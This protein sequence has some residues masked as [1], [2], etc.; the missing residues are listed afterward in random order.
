MAE[1]NRSTRP[2]RT[3]RAATGKHRATEKELLSFVPEKYRSLTWSLLLLLTLL[4]FFGGPIFGG[5]Y[6][7]ANDNISWESYRTYLNDMSDKGESPQWMPYVF[8]GMPGVAAYMVTGDRN[9]DLTMKGLQVAQ[10]VFS[11]LNQDIMRVL[12]Y[13]FLLGLG[14]F[15][16]LR[17]KGLSRPV[18]FFAAFAT[19]FSTWI[20]VWV[21]IGHN[22]KPMVLAFLPWIILFADRLIDRWSYLYAG[23]LILAIHYLVESAHPQTA[24]YGAFLI[25]IWLL[26]EFIASFVRKD[27][28]STGV[29]RAVLVG[30]AAALFAV[31]M[32]W[33]R[34]AVTLEY[35]EYSTRGA[36]PIM[37][38]TEQ[39]P[40]S[41]A[42]SWSQDVDETFTYIVPTYFGFGH[43]QLDVAGLPKEPIPTYW[44]NEKAPFTDA[45]HYM[46]ILVLLLSIYGFIRYRSNPFVLGIGIAGI[47]GLLISFGA[48]FS[49]F[50]DIL[51][52]ILPVFGQFRAPSQSLVIFEFALPLISAFGLT[53]LLQKGREITNQK[54]AAQPFLIGA[55]GSAVFFFIVFAIKSAYVSA[56][57]SDLG[58]KKM[59][60]GNV[61]PQ[62]A[63][64]VFSIVQL[65]WILTAL[66]AG[67]FFLLAWSYLKGKISGTVL[68]A[69]V[70]LI[71][72]VDLWRVDYRPMDKN[73]PREQ[74]FAVFNPTPADQ[75]LIAKNDSSLFRI[76]D[77]SRGSSFPAHFRL[78]HI[79]G[80]SAAKIRRYQDLMDFTNNGSTGMPGPGL[81]WDILNTRYVVSPQ[82]PTAETDIEVAPGVYERPTAMP[83]A[84]FVNKVEVADDKKVL[85][86][87]RDNTFN[88]REVAYVPEA[89]G[90]EIAPIS[91]TAA[92][93]S[94][95]GNDAIADRVPSNVAASDSRIKFTTWEPHLIEIDV[96]APANNFMVLSEI[97]YPPGWHAAIDGQ[98]V[99][100][101]R[102]DYLLRG[103]VI[104]Q[105]KH[106]VRY[107]YKSDAHETGVMISLTLNIITLALIAFGV[108]TEQRRKKNAI[109]PESSE[110]EEVAT[111]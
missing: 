84:W 79:G 14:V 29:I 49:I 96:D 109:E 105:G 90:T 42:T 26:T 74:A 70:I 59:F 111:T 45:G 110:E 69:S 11:F 25:G 54:S 30:I 35:N 52:N 47:F 82:G 72:V 81:A 39:D 99:E 71:T 101:I 9:W 15:A 75:F 48:N 93:D 13:Y 32:G 21:M 88:P 61:P 102:T 2:Q 91:A 57:S 33:D 36:D 103:L 4:I 34:F 16:L 60:G 51:Y 22:T 17:W 94:T 77:F 80:Y 28:R 10:D 37:E 53:A 106:T 27:G 12:F 58:M 20:I 23:L 46:G 97:F 68:I 63:E 19:I 7:G 6:F 55:I 1:T 56:I 38:Q 5:E 41:Y 73:E 100:T 104:P 65:D 85:E 78:Q 44:G 67:A 31:G 76:A 43:L 66:F 64:G 92:P 3:Q 98:P 50:Y 108:Y 24:M 95:G 87:I 40:Y 89:L 107:E 62:V 8:S 86:M 83:R 18:S